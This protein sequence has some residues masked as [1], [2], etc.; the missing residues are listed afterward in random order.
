LYKLVKVV[1]N[2]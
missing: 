2:M 1:L